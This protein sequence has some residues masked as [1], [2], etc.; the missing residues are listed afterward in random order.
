[1]T[2][3]VAVYFYAEDKWVPIMYYTLEEAITLYQQAMLSGMKMYIFPD[4]WKPNQFERYCLEHIP[5][6][7][8]GVLNYRVKQGVA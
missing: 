7:S 6:I 4:Q 5:Q 2:T 1:M 3:K 8:T